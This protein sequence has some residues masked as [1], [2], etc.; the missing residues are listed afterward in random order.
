MKTHIKKKALTRIGITTAATLL[1]AYW[2]QAGV[3][4]RT[5]AYYQAYLDEINPK[6]VAEA[7]GKYHDEVNRVNKH[8]LQAAS[9]GAVSFSAVVWSVIQLRVALNQ[10]DVISKNFSETAA[11]DA[12]PEI[13][14]LN[15]GVTWQF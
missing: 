7:Y 13:S 8:Q 14:E 9:V 11:G 5:E 2:F 1:C 12:G 6:R 3:D 4:N 15:V 10:V